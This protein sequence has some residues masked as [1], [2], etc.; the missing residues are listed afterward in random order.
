MQKADIHRMSPSSIFEVARSFDSFVESLSFS[1][2]SLYSAYRAPAFSGS[3]MMLDFIVAITSPQLLE[4]SLYD[5]NSKSI[6]SRE[7][8]AVLRLLCKI[9]SANKCIF[10]KIMLTSLNI[11]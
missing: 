4:C 9:V 5:L 11:H 6:S 10:H 7:K 8:R 1:F 3:C 2:W